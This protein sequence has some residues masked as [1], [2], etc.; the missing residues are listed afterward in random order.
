MTPSRRKDINVKEEE[1]IRAFILNA[2]R[3]LV[4]TEYI[5]LPL[6]LDEAVEIVRELVNDTLD[7]I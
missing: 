3:S 2:V 4:G 7:D 1:E 6:T 5:D